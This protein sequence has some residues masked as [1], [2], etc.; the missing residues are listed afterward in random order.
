MSTDQ[1]WE[2]WGK[3]N[4]YYG[5]LSA[6]KF[7]GSRLDKE[8]AEE[9]YKLGEYD[10]ANVMAD[11]QSLSPNYKKFSHAVDFGCG[12]G[13]LTVPLA[14]H[15]KKVTGLDVSPSMI[16]TACK[17]LTKTSKRTITYE[18]CNDELAGLPKKYDLVHSYIVL[19]H[20]PV[21]RGV[22]IIDKLLDNLENKGFAAL[23]VTFE[24]NV[25]TKKRATVWVR[26][27]IPFVHQAGNIAKNKPMNT[28]LMRMHT[29]DLN[30]V[31]KLF[32]RHGISK[33][34]VTITD[35]GGYMGA[36][37]VGQKQI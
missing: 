11:I 28:P 31:V 34:K 10:I 1:D 8:A 27:N 2:K 6:E 35:H 20:I 26:E 9:F 5:V 17:G 33:P 23:H 4:P 22:K 14:K 18:V 15:A 32:N 16:D 24:R 37:I 7:K 13:R 21:K 3:V 12:V 36:M 29:Y 19:Q 25:G 30:A